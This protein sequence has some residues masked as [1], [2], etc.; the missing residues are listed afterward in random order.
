[1]ERQPDRAVRPL[2][3]A[4]R[5]AAAARRRSSIGSRRAALKHF[6]KQNPALWDK[7]YKVRAFVGPA[8]EAPPRPLEA[9]KAHPWR[10]RFLQAGIGL[11][12]F[13]RDWCRLSELVAGVIGPVNTFHRPSREA[14]TAFLEPKISLRARFIESFS[15]ARERTGGCRAGACRHEQQ[16]RFQMIA[17]TSRMPRPRRRMRNERHA[18]SADIDREA[19]RHKRRHR[20]LL[21]KHHQEPLGRSDRG[22][23]HQ[24][25]RRNEHAP[26]S[27]CR[28]PA[29]TAIASACRATRITDNDGQRRPERPA[30]CHR[31][32]GRKT[33]AVAGHMTAR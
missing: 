16:R 15:A 20:S 24:A 27:R 3:P 5:R 28:S 31:D 26:D 7:A 32:K 2:W 30:H 1:M 6:I 19:P 18:R 21:P 22:A 12:A 17:P 4:I 8:N 25:D 33:R 13:A 9:V 10:K 14:R 23:G 11:A 29:R